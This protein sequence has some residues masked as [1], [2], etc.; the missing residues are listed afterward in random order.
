METLTQ[1][2]KSKKLCRTTSVKSKGSRRLG[3]SDS[4]YVGPIAYHGL[5]S[6]DEEGT[7]QSALLNSVKVVM[8][9]VVQQSIEW[10]LDHINLV[11]A[12]VQPGYYPDGQG[13]L[14]QD[15]S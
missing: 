8:I 14:S 5:K 6:A 12:F 15:H 4:D 1:G 13:P 9:L 3:E 10:R 11:A 7:V 2:Q